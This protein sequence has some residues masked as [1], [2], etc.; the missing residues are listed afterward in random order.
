MPSGHS[1]SDSEKILSF[2]D[3]HFH[4]P[5]SD[6]QKLSTDSKLLIKKIVQQIQLGTESWGKPATSY[7]DE[8]LSLTKSDF[9]KGADY[10]YVENAIK[11]E[12]E[13]KEKIGKHYFFKIGSRTF[14]VYLIKPIEKGEVLSPKIQQKIYTLFDNSIKK[15]YAW[16]YTASH[17]SEPKC[18]PILDIYIYMTNNKKYLS[19]QTDNL[20]VTIT[21]NNANTA[22]TFAC[23]VRNN[24]IYIYRT[25][26]WF[27]VLIHETFHSLGMDFSTMEQSKVD[28]KILGLFPNIKSNIEDL[29]PYEAYCECWAEIINVIFVSI[30]ENG[31][32]SYQNLYKII[33]HK[34]YNEQL[35]SIFQCVK[36]LQYNGIRFRELFEKS[37]KTLDKNTEENIKNYREKTSVFSYYVLKSV[38]MYHYNNFIEWSIEH[39]N[40]SIRF[41]NTQKNMMDFYRFI[42]QNYIYVGFIQNVEN[43][44]RWFSNYGCFRNGKCGIE[45]RTL[46][47]SISE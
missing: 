13:T 9:P 23:P 17:F 18:S 14:N 28:K 10:Y 45:L 8:I 22:F 5:K 44:E 26:E 33:E 38:L 2:I 4:I 41:K 6:R 42:K 25:E 34:M 35:F 31:S 12:F 3:K 27:K 29:R 32:N 1:G 21:S 46:R 20:S 15:I 37:G 19:E 39:N 16:L 24:E 36:V 43:I 40:N 30:Q 7:K 47:M 11:T